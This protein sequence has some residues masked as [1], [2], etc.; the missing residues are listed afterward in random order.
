MHD[1]WTALRPLFLAGVVLVATHAGVS[2]QSPSQSRALPLISQ[3]SPRLVASVFLPRFARLGPLCD[4]C[5]E[6]DTQASSRIA[7]QGPLTLSVMD[8][9]GPLNPGGVALISVA[10]THDLT[11]L[12]GEA[13]GRTVRFWRAA[14]SREWSGLVGINLDSTPGAVTLTIHGTSTTGMTATTRVPLTVA[15]YRFETRR[16]Q[17]DPKLVNPPESEL[18]RI[19][20]EAKAMADAF[21]IVTPQRYWHGRFDAPVPGTATSSFGRLTITNGKPA[22]RHQGAD[23][24]AA[25]GT[26][27][28][29]PNGGRVVIAR[30]LYFAGN[31]V[32][33]DHGLGVFSLLAHLSRI[34]VAPGA[35]VA[36]GDLVGE[37]GA[38]GRVTGP[39][40]HWAVRFGETTVD[41]IALMSALARQ[42]D[43]DVPPPSH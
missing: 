17:V 28:K 1:S 31:T 8:T 21:A 16:L 39:H 32:I 30:N 23:F 14:S 26:P 20:E 2:T 27:V 13:A 3:Q 5:N 42:S 38:T 7:V 9:P 34:D 6:Y 29:A 15:R 4:R 22:G 11:D 10:S 24:R 35:T 25:T 41:P 40:L 12:S 36:R 18:A 19:K 43:E 33:I 37:S